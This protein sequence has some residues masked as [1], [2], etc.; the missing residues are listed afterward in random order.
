MSVGLLLIT[1]RPLG[2]DLLR[3]SAGIFGTCPARAESL[4]V[5]NDAPCDLMLAEA[6]LLARR[7][8]AGDG[9]LVLTDLYGA[10]PANIALALRDRNQRVRVVAG[11]NLPMVLRALNYAGLDLDTVAEKALAGGRNG[12]RLCPEPGGTTDGA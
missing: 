9:V 2:A 1:H 12:I 11:V 6:E 10:T 5:E 4:D 8:D 3:V 7:L